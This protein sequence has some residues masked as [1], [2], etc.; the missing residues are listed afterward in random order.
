[1][2][3]LCNNISDKLEIFISNKSKWSNKM[4]KPSCKI[5]GE[6]EDSHRSTNQRYKTL[7]IER[8]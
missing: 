2:Y 3:L 4:T 7:K 6:Y 1:M 5:C 8:T